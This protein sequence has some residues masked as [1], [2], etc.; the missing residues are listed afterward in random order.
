MNPRLMT[1]MAGVVAGLFLSVGV[2]S[3]VAQEQ[4][5]SDHV[6]KDFFKEAAQG[7]MAEVTLGQMAA[8]KG[9][10]EAVKSYGQRMV[11]DHGKANDELKN[12]AKSEGVTLPTEMSSEAKDV[13]LRLQ[14]LSGTEFDQ[15]YMQEML[16]DHE[17][18]IE[19]FNQQA[20]NG[21][22][23]EVKNWAAKTLPTLREHK[24]L[25]QTTAEKIGVKTSDADS[26]LDRVS[27]ASDADK[28]M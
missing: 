25:G 3:T 28:A 23:P 12:L 11:K 18:D 9:K 21:A 7:G 19:A 20:N 16:K 10:N 14:K 24:Q 22:D 1:G 17:K 2:A 15:A 8:D 27:E 6:A 13:Q 5:K 26:S 4:T